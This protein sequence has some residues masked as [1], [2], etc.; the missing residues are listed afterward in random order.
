MQTL[1]NKAF[2]VSIQWNVLVRKLL[3][4]ERGA[5]TYS[6]NDSF[7]VVGGYFAMKTPFNP[8][9]TPLKTLFKE[10]FALAFFR[11]LYKKPFRHSHILGAQNVKLKFLL[12]HIF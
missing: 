6:K 9:L 7:K 1:K 10:P 5:L 4:L 2:R 8:Q 11:V 12:A 3:S